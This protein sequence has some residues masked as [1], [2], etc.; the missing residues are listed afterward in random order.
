MGVPAAVARVQMAEQQIPFHPPDTALTLHHYRAADGG[1]TSSYVREIST[2]DGPR[3]SEGRRAPKKQEVG[4]LGSAGKTG[5]LV[6]SGSSVVLHPE[7]QR[8]VMACR[9]A[10]GM[11]INPRAG[12]EDIQEIKRKHKT[13]HV[14][15]I[16][17]D[18]KRDRDQL[19]TYTQVYQDL[20]RGQPEPDKKFF[21][22]KTS[23]TEYAEAV[24]KN[25]GLGGK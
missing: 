12:L 15:G 11:E 8:L 18:P 4:G 1:R 16:F 20:S 19:S 14:S 24:I 17:T 9:Q 10:E 23:A 13:D 5:P 21:M 2:H 3:G 25:K 7:I 6:R 22:K